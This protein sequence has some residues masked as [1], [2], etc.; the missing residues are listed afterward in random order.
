M[1]VCVVAPIPDRPLPEPT[2]SAVNPACIRGCIRGKH[3]KLTA[4]KWIQSRLFT[5]LLFSF[6][7]FSALQQGLIVWQVERVDA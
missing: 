7:S 4:L 3:T 5:D 1:K 2:K 6:L